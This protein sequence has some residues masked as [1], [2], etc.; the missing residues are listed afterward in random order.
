MY[1]Y[2]CKAV[3]SSVFFS[4]VIGTP[5]KLYQQD[6]EVGGMKTKQKTIIEISS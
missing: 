1:M 2:T 4:A 5:Y 6:L 3:Y